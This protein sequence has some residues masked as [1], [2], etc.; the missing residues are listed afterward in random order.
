MKATFLSVV[1][2]IVSTAAVPAARGAAAADG[3]ERPPAVRRLDAAAGAAYALGAS[4]SPSFR[5]LVAALETHHVVVHVVTGRPRIF[6]AV[7]A[8]RLVG[9]AG[10]RLYLRVDLDARVA[11]DE[12][13]AV[14]AHELRHALEIAEAAAS[15][16]DEMRRLYERIGRHSGGT[17]YAYETAAA[18]AEGV[19]VLREI[20]AFVAAQTL[21][22][23]RADAPQ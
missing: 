11:L 21:R 5:A 12:R 2:L 19:Q 14:L 13:A 8:T 16:Q 20:R 3:E 9:L 6:G 1:L 15:T 18:E 22:A 4:A 17:L 7:G 10:G 23:A